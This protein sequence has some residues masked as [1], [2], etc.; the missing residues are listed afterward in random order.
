MSTHLV[1]LR[2]AAER[3][4]LMLPRLHEISERARARAISTWHGRMMTEH[5]S[6]R[7]FAS[8]FVQGMAVGLSH[9]QLA[10]IATFA[11]QELKHGVLCARVVAALGGDPRGELESARV[12]PVPLHLGTPPLEGLLRNVMSISCLHE[13][14][15]VALVGTEREQVGPQALVDVFTTIVS[16]EIKHARFG[17]LLLDELAPRL[18]DP[19]RERLGAYLVGAFEH[20]LDHFSPLAHAPD[21]TDEELLLGASD[22]KGNWQLVLD[23]VRGVIIPGIE[24]H[25]IPA[26]AAFSAAA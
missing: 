2:K 11:Q 15:A 6:S 4:P 16:D 9:E 10:R 26:R 5:V 20:L 21:A 18:D 13:T 17:W 19:L 24:R 1:D 22:G 12:A 23:T 14:I 25:H 3:R 8:L 7:V